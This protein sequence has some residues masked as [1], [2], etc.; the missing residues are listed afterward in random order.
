M[1]FFTWIRIQIEVWLETRRELQRQKYVCDSCENLKMQLSNQNQLINKLLEKPE[2]IEQH[3]TNQGIPVTKP[4]GIPWSVQRQRIEQESRKRADDL[5]K[6][7]KEEITDLEKQVL[8]GK[9]NAV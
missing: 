9:A 4:M 5:L 7:K 2:V 3:A 6:N 1:K 8:E